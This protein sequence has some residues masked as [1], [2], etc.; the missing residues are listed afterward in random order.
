[1]RPG[2]ESV[3]FTPPGL[4]RRLAR[5]LALAGVYAVVGRLGLAVEPVHLFASLVWAPT[6]IAL[7]ALL[8][9]G[10][11]YWPGV[12]LG[13]VA[14]NAWTGAPAGVALA[15]GAGNTLEAVAAALL[16]RRVCGAGWS[17]ERLRDV[18]AFIALAA[19]ASTALSASV[20]VSSLLAAGLL[21]RADLAATWRVW[22][23]GD[24]V[25]AL[26][27]G[28]LL[29]AWSAPRRRA[30]SARPGAEAVAL[31]VVLAAMTAF[32]FLRPPVA[33]PTG[34]VQATLLLPLLTW[35][36]VRFEARGATAAVFLTCAIAVAGT[37]SGRGPF[38]HEALSTS[39]LHQQ[40][41]MALVAV[42]VLMVGAVTA[43]RRRA[44]E[45]VQAASRAKDEF[46]AVLS[47]ELRNPLAPV[48]NGL[49]LLRLAP[50]GSEQAVR[51]L[52][53]VERQVEQLVRLVDDLLDAT[54][55]SRGKIQL[56]RDRVELVALVRD[57]AEDHRPLFA[58]RRIAL[59]L[60]LDAT[61]LW[62][63][64]DATRVRQIVGNLLQNA[65]K[66]TNAGGRVTVRASRE[67]GRAAIRVADDGVGMSAELLGRIFEP[68]TQGDASLH[69]PFGG[70]GLG[71]ALVKGLAALHGGDVEARSAGPGAGSELIVRLPLAERASATAGDPALAPDA[72]RAPDRDPGAAPGR[73]PVLRPRADTHGS[74]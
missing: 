51:A 28:S 65:A 42:A 9:G 61:P 49:H 12:G 43:E 25:G 27:V 56:H 44:E 18:L 35:T 46:L 11:G 72:V 50:P 45:A 59:D 33:A 34:F 48:R 64:A 52:A 36:A 41:F 32:V 24:A 37:A 8:R 30:A 16:V 22:W 53:I 17:L 13:A 55:V 29:L 20:G 62:V 47:H 23:L 58:G 70:L 60:A 40:A 1:L 68:F 21:P 63:D 2:L 74:G 3:S 19:L 66:F 26:V 71:L 73:A 69:R 10:V 67:P 4:S 6:G 7:A 38:V 39:L 14:A 5:I 57:T 31:G 15:I 54:R